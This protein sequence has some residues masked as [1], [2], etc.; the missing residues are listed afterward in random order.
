MGDKIILELVLNFGAENFENFMNKVRSQTPAHPKARDV[1]E[2]FNRSG[3][4]KHRT[5]NFIDIIPKRLLHGQ[6]K[7]YVAD[8]THMRKIT[9]TLQMTTEDS[10]DATLFNHPNVI[11]MQLDITDLL[12]SQ[13]KNHLIQYFTNNA[14]AKELPDYLLEELDE[15]YIKELEIE[16]M[17]RAGCSVTKIKGDAMLREKRPSKP[18]EK[19]YIRFELFREKEQLELKLMREL[20]EKVGKGSTDLH[21]LNSMFKLDRIICRDFTIGDYRGTGMPAVY[22]GAVMDNTSI[23]RPIR[24]IWD[25]EVTGMLTEEDLNILKYNWQEARQQEQS[26]TLESLLPQV[27]LDRNSDYLINEIAE[28]QQSPNTES[29]FHLDTQ[30]KTYSMHTQKPISEEL[31]QPWKETE[32]EL[33]VRMQKT[34][35]NLLFLEYGSDELT[36]PNGGGLLNMNKW[37]GQ[38][39]EM[40]LAVVEKIAEY[41]EPFNTHNFPLNYGYGIMENLLVEFPQHP[42]RLLCYCVEDYCAELF[43]KRV[44]DAELQRR[45]HGTFIQRQAEF[46]REMNNYPKTFTGTFQE[47]VS[48]EQK[49]QRSNFTQ[50]KGTRW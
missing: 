47:P 44:E 37:R 22:L 48:Y 12:S 25:V 39:P 50:R 9:T 24:F 10:A 13:K 2:S 3:S 36:E 11:Y 49:K 45:A 33:Q 5:F 15:I 6:T 23:L 19:M 31:K 28:G 26:L 38:V 16:P 32:E 27:L 1:I 46:D 20:Q 14:V 4:G 41:A 35:P 18:A 42:T 8:S 30:L 34:A 40:P 43:K 21:P 17:H 29:F 7:V